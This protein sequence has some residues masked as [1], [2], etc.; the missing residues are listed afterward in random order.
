MNPWPTQKPSSSPRRPFRFY[1]DGKWDRVGATWMTKED[2]LFEIDDH[3]EF[4][5]RLQASLPEAQHQPET[6]VL[7]FSQGT[8]T[9]WRWLM[10]GNVASINSFSG[11][12]AFPAMPWKKPQRA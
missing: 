7:A 9:A 2:R 11:P 4:L 5:N 6:I 1:L 10:K 8:A 12:A 3:I